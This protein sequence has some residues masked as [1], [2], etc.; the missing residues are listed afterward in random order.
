MEYR[1]FGSKLVVRLERGEEVCAKLL[2][3]AERENIRTA[4][5]SGMRCT[6]LSSASTA[7]AYCGWMDSCTWEPK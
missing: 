6:G 4:A 1:R 3:L 2:E 7:A 5:V